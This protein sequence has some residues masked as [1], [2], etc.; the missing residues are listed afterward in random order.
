MSRPRFPLTALVLCLSLV[1]LPACSAQGRSHASG[2]AT[3][4]EVSRHPDLGKTTRGVAAW[5]GKNHHGKPTSDGGRFNMYD[6]TAAHRT[7]PFGTRVK[8][9]NLR[10]HKSVVVRIT[11]RGP[12]TKRLAIDVSRQ[13]AQDLGMIRSGTAP[14]TIEVVALPKGYKGRVTL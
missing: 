6:Y 8:V 10:N 4:A 5:Y 12:Y 11:D 7:L 1:L 2:K 13:A 9:T 3:A 14:V